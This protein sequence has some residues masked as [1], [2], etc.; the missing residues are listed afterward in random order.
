MAIQANQ[1]ERPL[2]Y[3]D[4]AEWATSFISWNERD[5]AYNC[6]WVFIQAKLVERVAK[7]TVEEKSHQGFTV[8]QKSMSERLHGQEEERSLVLFQPSDKTLCMVGNGQ[9]PP[10]R[11]RGL[12]RL[13]SKKTFL[14]QVHINKIH[15]MWPL[16]KFYL[17]ILQKH[18]LVLL[19]NCCYLWRIIL[20]FLLCKE[21]GHVFFFGMFLFMGKFISNT[22]PTM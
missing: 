4:D 22:F 2:S 8:C 16:R 7:K 13:P 18:L 11:G 6:H 15:H 21:N 3:Y 9:G 12:Q 19:D 17:V 20:L 5:S 10:C 14:L 1:W